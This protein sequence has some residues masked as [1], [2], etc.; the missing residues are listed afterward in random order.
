MNNHNT[1][2]NLADTDGDGLSDYDEVI[3]YNTDPLLV[4][5]DGDGKYF[6]VSVR[7]RLVSNVEPF[8]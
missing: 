2:P 3:L 8:P 5:T 1:D 4:D 7:R 6:V